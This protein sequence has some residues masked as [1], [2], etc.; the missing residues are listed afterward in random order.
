MTTP[1][2]HYLVRVDEFE[3]EDTAIEITNPR[4]PFLY[5]VAVESSDEPGVLVF[6]DFGYRTA[7]EARQAWPELRL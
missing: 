1:R 7:D 3:G 5:C 4:D 2:R 6:V